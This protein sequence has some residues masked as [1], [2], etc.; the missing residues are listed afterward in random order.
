MVPSG[1]RPPARRARRQRSACRSAV[2]RHAPRGR[3]PRC[4]PALRR[5]GPGPADASTPPVSPDRGFRHSVSTG[6]GRPG[7]G[8]HAPGRRRATPRPTRR[9]GLLRGRC[10][11]PAVPG[12]GGRGP[13]PGSTALSPPR[14]G[15]AASSSRTMAQYDLALMGR[16][17]GD[18]GEPQP[19]RL[20]SGV[21]PRHLVLSDQSGVSWPT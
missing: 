11:V 20:A 12:N 7:C 1:P 18:V 17:F 2:A 19:V 8:W 13:G 6:R 3:P 15:A 16:V 9:A 14:P 4:S 21:V 10:A 5:R